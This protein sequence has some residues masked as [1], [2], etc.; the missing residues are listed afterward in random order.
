VTLMAGMLNEHVITLYAGGQLYHWVRMC[1]DV[2]GDTLAEAMLVGLLRK[3]VEGTWVT[4]QCGF[5]IEHIS[6]SDT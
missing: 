5:S 4:V 3:V 1:K 6:N 2:G